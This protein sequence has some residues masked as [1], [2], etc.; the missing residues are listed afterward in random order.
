MQILLMIHSIVRWLIVLVAIVA[1]VKFALGWLRGGTFGSTGPRSCLR[2]YRLDG[3]A[4]YDRTY[5]AYLE[6]P[7]RH[8]FPCIPH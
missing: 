4:S 1:A 3:P 2:F 5:S 6:R 8:R 7:R